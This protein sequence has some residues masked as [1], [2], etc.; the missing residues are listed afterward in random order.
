MPFVSQ[1]QEKYMFATHPDIADKMA[2]N[3]GQTGGGTKKSVAAYHKLPA[4]AKS[5]SNGNRSAGGRGIRGAASPI[6]H[7]GN[8]VGKSHAKGR[9]MARSRGKG[10]K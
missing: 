4:S 3:S 7:P 6:H 9:A 2:H 10:G 8:S 1:K 5:K